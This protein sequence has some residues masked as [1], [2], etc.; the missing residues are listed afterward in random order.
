MNKR[1]QEKRNAGIPLIFVLLVLTITYALCCILF[2]ELAIGKFV[3]KGFGPGH[4]DRHGLKNG[5]EE[6]YLKQQL[7]EFNKAVKPALNSQEPKQTIEAAFQWKFDPQRVR[8][9]QQLLLRTTRRLSPVITAY[10]EESPK[11][12]SSQN[13]SF[14]Q[15]LRTQSP[16]SL[17]KFTYERLTKC[18]EM[19]TKFP[20][21]HPLELN[22]EYRNV[23]N[24][25]PMYRKKNHFAKFC[26]VDADPYLPWI[27]DVFPSMNV[28]TSR[29]E[30]VEILAQN[31]RRCNTDDN[32]FRGDLENLQPQVAI[33]QP[34]PIT[35]I[36]SQ[37]AFLLA[38]DLWSASNPS[39]NNN[40]L[41]DV[42][43]DSRATV[44]RY[45]LATYEDADEDSQETRFI[46]RFYTFDFG[47]DF[48][49]TVRKIIL[50]ETL[51]VFP[52]NYEY[53]AYRKGSY[54]MLSDGGSGANNCFWNSVQHF[55]C[56]VPSHLQDLVGHGKTVVNDVA[57]IYLA[58]V[59]I[60]TR[61]RLGNEQYFTKRMVGELY[62]ETEFDPTKEWGNAH[63]LPEVEASGRWENIPL[64]ASPMPGRSPNDVISI[65][66][67]VT[68]ASEAG[69]DQGSTR[70]KNHTLIACVWASAHFTTR[71]NTPVDF[72]TSSRLK[73]WIT[74]NL[75]V[76]NM[77]HIYV[78]DNSGA[79][80]NELTL[81][82]V[83]D[84]FPR[85][86]VTRIDWPF[87][88]CNNNIPAHA[89]TGERSSQYAAEASCRLRFG[90][91]SEFL[92]SIDT[93]EYLI[94]M[95]NWTDLKHWLREGVDPETK[96][97]S[98]RSTRASPNYDFMEPYWDGEKCG[99]NESDARCVIKRPEALYL[100]TYNCDHN[101][102]P[103]PEWADRAKK[104]I[105]R[106][107]YV[108]NH[109]VHYSTVTKGTAMLHS[110]AEE[111]HLS[112]SHRH[113]ER[114]PS[115]RY[116]DDL[117]EATLVQILQ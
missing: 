105:Y 50:G 55:R 3:H 62:K 89:N 22:E 9:V 49:L 113:H 77:D 117:L 66:D 6:S 73:E 28:E 37:E 33:M 60:R 88:V 59:P 38:P 101:P 13:Y 74:Y 112:W 92:A 104:Q 91:F 39:S 41:F 10:V 52:Y 24:R 65:D 114:R 2:F 51:S 12:T 1:G 83:T 100:E 78:Y 26:P 98:F 47:D 110:E 4:H 107:S 76:A 95:G 70:S 109:Y 27:H 111:R 17:K 90:R 21:N 86:K 15:P 80:T 16:D 8:E 97:L 106:P 79:H 48:Q 18:S 116:A 45:R 40:S 30:Y 57:S 20:V 99:A 34:V 64:C 43:V 35:R 81:A 5:R 23:N 56:P 53:A 11:N 68:A 85:E 71:G 96:I 29:A 82:N 102:L 69:S 44:S 36:S 42:A 46:C 54:P 63:V 58:I 75:Y 67:Q 94:P 14:R 87:R 7:A 31:K 108:L 115:E 19:P 32:R 84:L 103:K 61:V 72:S 93:D 25:S